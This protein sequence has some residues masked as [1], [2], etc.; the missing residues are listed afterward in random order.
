MTYNTPKNIAFS[1]AILIATAF[2]IIP[3]RAY[4][5]DFN[6]LNPIDPFCLFSCDNHND[7]PVVQNTTYTNTNSNNINSYNTNSTI[8]ATSY[9]TTPVRSTTPLQSSNPTPVVQ[10]TAPTLVY[11]DVPVPVY[12]DVPVPVYRDVPVYNSYSTPVYR[13]NY[14]YIEQRPVVVVRPNP[15]VVYDYPQYNY[16]YSTLSA[17]CY[18]TPSRTNVG[19]TVTWTANV[20]GGNGAYSYTWNGTDSLYGYNQTIYR[21]YSYRGTKT[22]SVTV[23]SGNQSVAVNCYNSVIIDDYTTYGYNYIAPSVIYTTQYASPSILQ[24]GCAVDSPSATIGK[25]VTWSAEATGAGGKY[26]Y[27]WSGTDSLFGTQ[28]SA[29]TSYSTPGVKNAI[30]TVTAT[31]GESVSKVCT[32]TVTV[33]STVV[34][35]TPVKTTVAVVPTE[36]VK[37]VVA[38]TPITPDGANLSATSLLSLQNVP[39][40]LVATLLILVLLGMVI[41]L[42]VNRNK[43]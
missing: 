41:Y 15:V 40:A 16:T 2:I 27:S 9:N 37:P 38:V 4:A 42:F 25:P 36:T 18:A 3:S 35:K 28:S 26:T 33:K 31:N 39:W 34:A 21:E 5:V 8:G 30:V 1:V 20:S 6:P 17:N 43:I 24:V 10:P 29:I 12:R 19:A 22:A 23:T 13:D 11:R 32:N 7:Q 14:N